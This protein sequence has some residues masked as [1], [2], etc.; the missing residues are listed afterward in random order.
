MD[1]PPDIKKREL[2]PRRRG[3]SA[4][5]AGLGCRERPA[6]GGELLATGGE[7]RQRRCPHHEPEH[8][9]GWRLP[10]IC[11]IL[12]Q[13]KATSPNF[14]FLAAHDPLF[15]SL[16]TAAERAFQADP[17]TTVLKLRQLGEAFA[18]HAAAA[19]GLYAGPGSNQLD[20][21]RSLE[22]RGIIQGQSSELFHRL[23]QAGNRAAHDFVADHRLALDQL[24]LARQLAI[25]FH[26]TFG[27]AAGTSFKPGPFVEPED[28]SKAAQEAELLIQRLQAQLAEQAATAA[29]A[30]ALAEA[31]AA[32]RAAAEALAERA[33]AERAEWERLSAAYDADLVASRKLF[34]EQLAAAQA[35]AVAHPEQQQA[36]VKVAA[37]ATAALELS[38]A[39]TRVLV[40]DQLRR[41]GWEADSVALSHKAGARP[42]KGKNRAIAEWPAGATGWAD[43]VLFIGLTPVAIVEAKRESKDVVSV[44]E[45]AK[46]YARHLVLGADQRYALGA[47]HFL[48]KAGGALISRDADPTGLATPAGWFAQEKQGEIETYKV[49]FLFATNSR[50]YLRQLET[51][52]GIWFLDGRR[53]TNH[54]RPLLGWYTPDGIARLLEKDEVA[55]EGKLQ[56]EPTD[57]LGLRPYQLAAIRAVEDAVARGQQSCL[58]AMA[59]G[60]GKTRTIVGLIH[61]LL[62]TQRFRRVLF[63]VDREAL[64]TQAHGAFEEMLLDEDQ[65]FARKY[66]LNAPTEAELE[67][68]TR[69]QVATVQAMVRRAL[70]PNQDEDPL[71][72]DAFD[73]VIVDESHRGYTLDREMTEHEQELRSFHD[74]VSTYRRVLDHFDAVKVGLT[75]TPALHTKEIFGPPVFNYT[76]QEAV[77]DGF[78][79]DHEPPINFITELAQNGI[80]LAQGE[81]VG[82]LTHGNVE[83]AALPD[84]MSFEVSDFNKLVIAP[85]FTRVVAEA[86]ADW[87]DPTG[88]LKT[89]IFCV[90]DRHADA[91][92]VALKAA[93]AAKNFQ[94][95]DNAIAKIT[96][97]TDKVED[98]I[99]RYRNELTPNTAV[100]VDLL[101]TGIDVPSIG[102]LVFVR[103]VRSRIL[104]EQMLGRATRLHPG[105]VVFRVFDAVDIYSTLQGFTDMKPV[106]VDVSIPIETLLAE[107]VSAPAEHVELVRTQLV[108][109]LRRLHLRVLRADPAPEGLADALERLQSLTT[110]DLP[111]LASKLQKLPL[112]ELRAYVADRPALAP[113]LRELMDLIRGTGG[114]PVIVTG[115]G[116]QLVDV[117]RGYVGGK[118]PDDYLKAFGEFLEAQRNQVAALT[119]VLTRPRDL[120]RAQLRELRL[121]LGA[122]GYT[123]AGLR[124]A[125]RE[126]RD[127]DVAATIIGFIRQRALGSPLVP[128]EQRVDRALAKVRAMRAW[129]PPQKQWLDRIAKQLKLE[130]IVDRAV[131]DAGNFRAV[132][133]YKTLDRT[134]DGQLEQVLERFGE[135]IWSDNPAA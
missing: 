91:M 45:Q 80:Q 109:R 29:E 1:K 9:P 52:S 90:N 78:L 70:S 94:I 79:V 20:L 60:T 85:E 72:V 126:T 40:D 75:A 44:L 131:F 57:Y 118:K 6:T 47:R 125:W 48:T 35:A 62:K 117:Q 81:Q 111:A 59:T 14:A 134:L 5:R 26:R 128:Y 36:V 96:G 129:T 105:K 42:V 37:Q 73:L 31:E 74:Y 24:R 46:R 93:Y 22:A 133:G 108:A 56:E 110:G 101:T 58:V 43:Y 10:L 21:L 100:T 16:A 107:V 11:S 41:A 114:S 67:A 64:G 33:E 119:L 120:S 39:E 86:L 92:V 66:G 102:N 124:T 71:P 82:L 88:P 97:A 3:C 95:E 132:G 115:K 12:P 7:L 18:Q 4:W 49:P 23:R 103:R 38:E 99:R 8:L 61:R 112:A 106:V 27:G 69:V 87:I 116:D 19:T 2:K 17:A 113:L 28:P 13:L 65:T 76:Y 135:E 98:Q 15:V 123:E 25:W 63:L 50:P 89:L 84:E 83:L 130:V 51:A 54:P 122:V 77:V 53:P 55:A 32:R 30:R 121:L 34:G 68:S 104:Y 127:V